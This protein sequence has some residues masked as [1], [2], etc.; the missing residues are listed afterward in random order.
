MPQ[1]GVGEDHIFKGGTRK[2]CVVAYILHACGNDYAPETV[3][4]VEGVAA[5]RFKTSGEGYDR[6]AAAVVER[7][8]VDYRNAFGNSDAL[9]ADAVGKVL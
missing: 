3:I 8:V 9:K 1:G 7:E 5:Y 6:K 2:E 4:A